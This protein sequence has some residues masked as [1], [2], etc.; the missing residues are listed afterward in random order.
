MIVIKKIL[1]FL[2]FFLLFNTLEVDSNS[3]KITYYDT[4]ELYNKEVYTLYFDNMSSIKLD[5]IINSYD[6]VILSYFIDGKKYY[7]RDI[8]E[9]NNTI[10][11]DKSLSEKI[12][13]EEYGYIIDGIKV[14]CSTRDII[15]LKEKIHIY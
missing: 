13:Y 10:Y 8:D 14:L 6:L 7:A 3:D 1:I 15:M 9:L 5:Q 12:Y 2:C 11:K 4:N